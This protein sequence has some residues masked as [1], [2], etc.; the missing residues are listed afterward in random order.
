MK[1]SLVRGA[2]WAH[3]TALSSAECVKQAPNAAGRPA[4]PGAR[5]FA[6]VV[7]ALTIIYLL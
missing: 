2:E 6:K 1:G 4:R 5:A 7:F 3:P